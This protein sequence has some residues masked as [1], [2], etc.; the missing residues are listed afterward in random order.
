MKYFN[1]RGGYLTNN[2]D[3][4]GESYV[5][6]ESSNG[7]YY[8][9]KRGE[10]LDYDEYTGRLVSEDDM[11]WLDNEDR[12][13]NRDMAVYSEYEH[14]WASPEYAEEHWR[15]SDLEDDW[16]PK[17]YTVYIT[18]I[19]Q[20]VSDTYADEN[21]YRC[22]YDDEYYK[23][24]D[25]LE[26]DLHSYVPKNKAVFVITDEDV[27]LKKYV[28]LNTRN[29]EEMYFDRSIDVRYEGDKTYFTVTGKN[30]KEY[31]LDN[32]FKK[33]DFA[34]QIKKGDI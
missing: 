17:D 33:S 29:Y 3:E 11:V 2:D 21:F 6:L 15:Y 34:K 20:W 28:R 24:N 12:N 31:H 10:G 25:C 22:D 1:M 5:E 14:E 30:G 9:N 7:G 4:A 13:M 32:D 19:K 8:D 18:T 16:I 23:T 26:S 27:E